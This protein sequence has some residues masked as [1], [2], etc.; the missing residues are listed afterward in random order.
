MALA[1]SQLLHKFLHLRPEFVTE[2]LIAFS[3]FLWGIVA[4]WHFDA[5]VASELHGDHPLGGAR[6]ALLQ[7]TRELILVLLGEVRD[8]VC[9]WFSGMNNREEDFRELR[10]LH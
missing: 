5:G 2:I 3:G 9:Y 10:D 8:R 1:G 6:D 7:I 4:T